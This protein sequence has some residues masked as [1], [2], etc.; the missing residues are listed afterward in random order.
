MEFKPALSCEGFGYVRCGTCGL[1]QMNPQPEHTEVRRRYQDGYGGD[2]LSYELANEASFLRLQ[3]LAL[4]DAGIDELEQELLS[5]KS[6]KSRTLNAQSGT[7]RVLDIGCATGALLAEFRDRGWQTCGAEI[8]TPQ[9]EY[10]RRERGLDIREGPLEENHFSA[11]EFDLVLAS[12]LIEHLNDPASFVKEVFRILDGEGRFIV[13]TPNIDG[14]QSR[15]LKGRWRSA[16][17]D[18]LYL[19]SIKTLPALLEKTGF[20]IEK[21][22]TWGGLASGLGPRWIKT[23]MDRLAKKLGFGDVMLIRACK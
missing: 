17:F 5:A 9:A 13:T 10:A 22:V 2:Y 6:R 8:S 3:K 16:I 21:I 18:H 12:H 19:F 7:P 4:A 11:G 15:L 1:V 20:R 23:P 14:L